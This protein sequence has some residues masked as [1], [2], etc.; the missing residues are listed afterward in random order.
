MTDPKTAVASDDATAAEKFA[1]SGKPDGKRSVSDERRFQDA[2][3]D[4][5]VREVL[6][7]RRVRQF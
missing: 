1:N 6:L 5:E 2:L 4:D 7:S 3:E